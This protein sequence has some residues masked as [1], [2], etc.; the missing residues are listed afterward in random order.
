MD[1]CYNKQGIKVMFRK[2]MNANLYNLLDFKPG[3]P[4]AVIT[5]IG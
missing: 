4:S 5:K 3:P 2:V 1:I